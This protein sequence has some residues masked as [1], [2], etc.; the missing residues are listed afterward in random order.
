MN[1][2]HIVVDQENN[3]HKNHYVYITNMNIIWYAIQM[4][5]QKEVLQKDTIHSH[6]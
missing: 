3:K 1:H 2:F 6:P 5:Q 4:N